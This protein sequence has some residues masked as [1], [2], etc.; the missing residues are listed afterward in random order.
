M[1]SIM[2]SSS[3]LISNA[4]KYSPQSSLHKHVSLF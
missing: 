3:C 4:V 1:P 2:S